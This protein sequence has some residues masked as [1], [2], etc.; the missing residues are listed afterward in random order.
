MIYERE[1]GAVAL[2]VTVII[3]SVIFVI[4]SSMTVVRIIEI[5]FASDV[6][7]SNAAYEAADSGM[8][9]A[10]NQIQ[11]DS[12]GATIAANCPNGTAV[13]AGSYELSIISYVGADVE[14]IKSI[15]TAQG[16]KRAVEVTLQ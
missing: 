10:L 2:L 1:K 9:C 16:T 13:G 5:Q 4:A 3:L 15:G 7:E 11:E 14:K 8:E 12:T 6:S